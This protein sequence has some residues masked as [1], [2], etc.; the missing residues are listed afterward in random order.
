MRRGS[1]PTDKQ[2]ITLQLD[3]KPDLTLYIR[4]PQSACQRK[5]ASGSTAQSNPRLAI[6]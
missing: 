6:D 2:V 3:A 5:W 1:C 4:L